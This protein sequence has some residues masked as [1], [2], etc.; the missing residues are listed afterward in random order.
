MMY[1]QS[2][3][4]SVGQGDRLDRG[5]PLL[6]H[7]WRFDGYCNLWLIGW[8]GMIVFVAT[9]PEVR[10]P[11]HVRHVRTLFYNL[12]SQ[13]WSRMGVAYRDRGEAHGIVFERATRA[14]GTAE[15]SG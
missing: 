14:L 1:T 8:H 13:R 6:Q 9:R 2:D 7:P 4:F 5:V 11:L 3:T 10:R 15:N 12:Y